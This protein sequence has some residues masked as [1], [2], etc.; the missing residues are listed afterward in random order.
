MK[1]KRFNWFLAA[2]VIGIIYYVVFI[3]GLLFF[4]IK[5]MML[6]WLAEFVVSVTYCLIVFKLWRKK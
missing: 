3:I 1:K 4:G 2:A 5:G 6:A